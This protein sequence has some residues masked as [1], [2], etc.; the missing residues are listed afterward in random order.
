MLQLLRGKEGD[1]SQR[2]STY[3]LQINI[4]VRYRKTQVDCKPDLK[5]V[6]FFLYYHNYFAL[7]ASL[8][9][10]SYKQKWIKFIVQFSLNP[11]II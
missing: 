3:R 5:A 8:S 4:E 2:V 7:R 1:V 10:L 11:S 9:F 6:Y